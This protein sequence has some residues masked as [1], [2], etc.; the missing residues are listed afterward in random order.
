MA[1]TKTTDNKTKTV[2]APPDIVR[3][4][5]HYPGYISI[6][7]ASGYVKTSLASWQVTA[8]HEK[9]GQTQI[10]IKDG[11]WYATSALVDYVM[12]AL[13]QASEEAQRAAERHAALKRQARAHVK[14]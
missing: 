14:S 10:A 2:D 9:D 8:V 13:G 6:E 1:T 5:R 4:S 3:A 7:D 12:S 11:S